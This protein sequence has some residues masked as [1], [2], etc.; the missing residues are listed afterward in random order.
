MSESL[1]TGQR[2]VAGQASGLGA[3][4]FGRTGSLGHGPLVPPRQP[5]TQP[6]VGISAL[7]SRRP[8][9]LGRRGVQQLSARHEACLGT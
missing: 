2:C 9:T 3:D 6:R 8:P 1:L 5:V 4:S 7:R